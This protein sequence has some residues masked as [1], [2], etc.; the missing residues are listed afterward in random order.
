MSYMAERI[1]LIGDRESI[2]GFAAIG[3]DIIECDE[4]ER[5]S[6]V[7]RTAAES[8]FYTVI[9]MT[10]EMFLAAE[11]ERKKYEEKQLP[12]I[13]PIPGIKGNSGVGKARLSQFVERAVG[14]DI[15]FKN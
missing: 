14:S 12:A 8:E 10:E 5:A 7:L 3:F 4:P 6:S 13:V 15:L 9:F 11:K 1:A 2:K